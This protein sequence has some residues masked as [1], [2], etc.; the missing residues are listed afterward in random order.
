MAVFESAF[1]GSSSNIFSDIII[2]R[3]GWM[4][5]DGFLLQRGFCF[6]SANLSDISRIW[7]NPISDKQT[8]SR[9][10][11][12]G[13]FGG[14]SASTYHSYCKMNYLHTTS[15]LRLLLLMSREGDEMDACSRNHHLL[16][17]QGN[18]YDRNKWW[19]HLKFMYKIINT[20]HW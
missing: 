10:N 19:F 15:L 1:S 17:S 16:L 5:A 13:T 18:F 7:F 3:A 20:L 4:D 11:V 2:S 8:P 12:F 6:F 9:K 14:I